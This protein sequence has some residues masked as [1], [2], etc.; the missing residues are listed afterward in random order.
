MLSN[1]DAIDSDRLRDRIRNSRDLLKRNR[2]LVALD[3]TL[4][5]EWSGME[6]LRRRDPDWQALLDMAQEN[7]FKSIT[8]TLRKA[9]DEARNPM[10]F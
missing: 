1:A 9:W 3:S 5:A 4:P 2:Q 6:M 8:K 7:G 10:L